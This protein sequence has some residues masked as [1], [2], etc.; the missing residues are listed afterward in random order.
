MKLVLVVFLISQSTH[1]SVSSNNVTLTGLII[2]SKE[3]KQ[4]LLAVCFN[5]GPV[6][7]KKKLLH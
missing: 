4:R 5:L 1:V 2:V 7:S 3:I 6:A